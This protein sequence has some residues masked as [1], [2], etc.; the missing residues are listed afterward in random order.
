MEKIQLENL[1]R[2]I[3]REVRSIL[4]NGSCNN[5]IEEHQNN[6]KHEAIYCTRYD[7]QYYLHELQNESR[8][9]HLY[10]TI[11]EWS[12]QQSDK[13]QRIIN[14]IILSTLYGAGNCHPMTDVS[15]FLWSKY[16]AL[17]HEKLHN[18]YFPL[19]KIL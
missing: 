18:F 14:R 4:P 8:W 11:N 15:L 17:I 9:S 13:Q 1:C 16:Y 5:G 7:Y 12:A 19:P 6:W 10:L 2:T 3:M